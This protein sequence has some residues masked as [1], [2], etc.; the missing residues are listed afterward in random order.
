MNISF[1]RVFSDTLGGCTR[2]RYPPTLD[3][4]SVSELSV[5]LL[6]AEGLPTMPISGSRG[7][8]GAGRRRAGGRAENARVRRV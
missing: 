1:S 8:L 5:V 3:V 4:A 7:I 2:D 6:P